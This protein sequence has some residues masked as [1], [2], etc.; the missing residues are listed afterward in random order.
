MAG[1]ARAP[2]HRDRDPTELH[3]RGPQIL[4]RPERLFRPFRRSDRAVIGIFTIIG[5]AP[6]VKGEPV[7]Q[8][9]QVET[10]L[11]QVARASELSAM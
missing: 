2:S 7:Y 9:R 5:H 3:H 6:H 4:N 1:G 11:R 10:E 8:L